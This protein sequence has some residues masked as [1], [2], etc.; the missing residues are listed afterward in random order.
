[1]MKMYFWY[2]SHELIWWVYV[3]IMCI[4]TTIYDVYMYVTCIVISID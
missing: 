1:M 3:M 4:Y 2:I